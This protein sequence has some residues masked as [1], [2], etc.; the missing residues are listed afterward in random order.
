MDD[1]A[2]GQAEEVSARATSS[3]WKKPVSRG[4]R[5]PRS[6]TAAARPLSRSRLSAQ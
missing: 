5:H 6:V 2:D 4:I 1:Q 3:G